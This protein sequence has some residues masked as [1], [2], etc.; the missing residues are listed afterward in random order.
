MP[1]CLPSL[2]LFFPLNTNGRPL[3]T[4]KQKPVNGNF[5]RVKLRLAIVGS[6]SNLSASILIRF[7]PRIVANKYRGVIWLY[8]VG[9]LFSTIHKM[10]IISLTIIVLSKWIC[11]IYMISSSL[12]S[13]GSRT[14]VIYSQVA[15]FDWWCCC[16][17]YLMAEH[18]WQRPATPWR[19]YI[20]YPEEA[21]L[22]RKQYI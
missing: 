11:F 21:Y 17:L 13:H 9:Y 5:S 16:F 7:V 15:S 14:Y 1:L 22:H 3:K 2:W 20:S 10:A 19:K 4:T 6:A 8:T 12:G 18:Q